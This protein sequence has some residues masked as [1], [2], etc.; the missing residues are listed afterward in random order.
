[1]IDFFIAFGV[2]LLVGLVVG[3][4]AAYIGSKKTD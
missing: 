2:W 3:L 4:T 1:M